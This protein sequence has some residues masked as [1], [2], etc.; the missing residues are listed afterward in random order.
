MQW[1]WL[2]VLETKRGRVRAQAMVTATASIEVSI[3]EPTNE[4]LA[5][6]AKYIGRT[7]HSRN[8]VLICD[9]QC[10]IV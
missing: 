1:R 4:I 3:S 5:T 10:L 9:K 2:L 8:K 7:V 6:G